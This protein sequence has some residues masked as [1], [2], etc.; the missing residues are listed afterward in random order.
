MAF[1][2]WLHS[3]RLCFDFSA[4]GQCYEYRWPLGCFIVPLAPWPQKEWGRWEIPIECAQIKKRERVIS[5]GETWGGSTEYTAFDLSKILLETDG[6]KGISPRKKK[7]WARAQS[8]EMHGGVQGA[9]T[10]LLDLSVVCVLVTIGGKA[11]YVWGTSF[12]EGPKYLRTDFDIWSY[13]SK[14]TTK[15]FLCQRVIKTVLRWLI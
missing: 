7:S 13:R 14:G 9:Q 11:E 1:S 5:G 8:W 10:L 12:M 15:D 6:R 2:R 3:S 4:Q